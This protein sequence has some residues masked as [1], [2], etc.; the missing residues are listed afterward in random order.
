MGGVVKRIAIFLFF[1]QSC[2]FA[3]E[4]SGEARVSLQIEEQEKTEDPYLWD[5]GTVREGEISEHTFTIK[6]ESLKTIKIT[7]INT[8][9]G[10]TASKTEKETLMP[11]ETA[12]V[13]VSFN[14][15]GYSGA[16]QQY[17]YVNTDDQDKPVIKLTIKAKVVK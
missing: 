8:S 14:S 6:N 9:C 3:Q 5:F 11:G 12:E 1:L 7:G 4:T 13:K 10:C 15:K 16:V 2:C 17:A